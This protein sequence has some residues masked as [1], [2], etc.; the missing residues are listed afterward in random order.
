MLAKQLIFLANADS[1]GLVLGAR[2]PIILTSRADSVRARIA[3]HPLRW[4]HVLPHPFPRSRW[5]LARQCE[6]QINLAESFAGNDT[7]DYCIAAYLELL[8]KRFTG[9]GSHGLLYSQD[10][11]VAF[12]VVVVLLAIVIGGLL[13]WILYT[14]LGI[15][16]MGI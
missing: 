6:G 2:V 16:L 1:A 15:D 11:A 3:R 4:E 13:S 14:I 7:A 5:I 8:G 10:K 12:T 9:S